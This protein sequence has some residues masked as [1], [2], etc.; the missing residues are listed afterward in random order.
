MQENWLEIS[1]QF[2]TRERY[3]L[4]V[5]IN[6]Q[7]ATYRKAGTLML[8]NERQQ[9]TGLLSG[10]CLE[11]DIALHAQ[12]VFSEQNVK[13]LE[14][15]L[16]ADADLLW[17]LGLGCEGAIDILLLPL[18]PENNHLDFNVLLTTIEQRK[19]G[20]YWISLPEK[21]EELAFLAKAIFS[22]QH[23]VPK[24][25]NTSSGRWLS[26]PV[27]PAISVAILGAGPDA[28]P[29]ANMAI[30]MGWQVTV[31][32]HRENAL[33]AIDFDLAVN[34]VKLRAE[35]SQSGYFKQFNAAIVM[36]HNLSFDQQYLATLLTSEVSYIGLLGP[37]ARRDKMLETVGSNYASHAERVFGPVGLNIGGRSPQAI[38]LS[39][40]AEVQQQMSS[41]L[42]VSQLDMAYVQQ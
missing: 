10:G 6:T 9:C 21:G 12:A 30:Q 26:I 4:A 33:A 15:D 1:A 13:L 27:T 34:K 35:N 17:G 2:N 36:T 42:S 29:L 19:Q 7:G 5:I 16:T 11:A 14:Y 40:L 37:K 22:G 38:A 25:A 39:I 23:K 32:D 8:I 28:I 20:R 3:V 41:L 18:S 24:E 31:H